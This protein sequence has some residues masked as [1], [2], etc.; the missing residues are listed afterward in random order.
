[1]WLQNWLSSAVWYMIVCCMGYYTVFSHIVI[2]CLADS[3]WE[4]NFIYVTIKFCVNMT[5]RR[6][7]F[8]PTWHAAITRC[9]RS[10]SRRR[11]SVTISPVVMEVPALIH[12]RVGEFWPPP[13]TPTPPH[14]LT[15][16]YLCTGFDTSYTGHSVALIC[17]VSF[18]CNLC[19]PHHVHMATNDLTYHWQRSRRITL[20]NYTVSA[21]TQE[22]NSEVY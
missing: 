22:I 10:R 1:M 21:T 3:V 18:Y 13:P 15:P 2:F 9:P 7:W 6:E 4:T 17:M 14:P 5:M 11:A 19:S 12:Y 16:I 8:L 20:S